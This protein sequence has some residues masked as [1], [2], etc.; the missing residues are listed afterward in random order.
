MSLKTPPRDLRPLAGIFL[1][2][3]QRTST[4]RSAWNVARRRGMADGGATADLRTATDLAAED[5]PSGTA[6]FG[7]PPVASVMR[8]LRDEE[9]ATPSSAEASASASPTPSPFLSEASASDAWLQ[10]REG[11]LSAMRADYEA[12]LAQAKFNPLAGAGWIA[13]TFS[14]NES[15][16]PTPNEPNAVFV[17]DPGADP[18]VIGYDD[19]GNPLF[20]AA[21]GRWLVF[22]VATFDAAYQAEAGEPL[23]ALAEVYDTDVPGVL[24]LPG[25]WQIA[26]SA[27]ALRAGP[28]L[29]GEAMGD[30][31][32]LG[33]LD[34]YMAD[35]QILALIDA[36]GG[37]PA[38][39][40][41]P[42]ALDQVRLYGEARYQQLSRLDNAMHEVRQHYVLA[43]RQA[44]LTGGTGWTERPRM[45]TTYD[46]SGNT[47]TGPMYLT[48]EFGIVRDAAGQPVVVTERF[49]DADAFTCWYQRQSGLANEA[50][51]N[52][53][54]ASHAHYGTDEVGNTYLVSVDF[55]N[56]RWTV[57]PLIGETGAMVPKVLVGIDPNDR[58]GLHDD[59]AIGFDL[60]AG[61]VTPATNVRD[62]P[63]WFERIFEVA[64]VVYVGWVFWPMAQA[65]GGAVG[66]AL[67]TV[68]GAAATGAVAGSISAATSGFIAGTPQFKDILRGA[69]SGALTGGLLQELG[70]TL[71]PA[72][73]PFVTIGLNTTVNGAM[74]AL[75]GGNFA[76]GAL[77]GFAASLA[78]TVRGSLEGEIDLAE[79]QGSMTP[80]QADAAKA[81]TKVLGSAIRAAGNPADPQSAFA[82]AFLSDLIE[83]TTV[84]P[85]TAFDDDG[86]LMPGAV[87]PNAPV[88]SQMA[89]LQARLIAQGLDPTRAASLAA[90]YFAD[91]GLLPPSAYSTAA[92]AARDAQRTI[93]SLAERYGGIDLVP[94]GELRPLVDA[95]QPSL[96]NLPM[97]L[98]PRQL[99]ALGGLAFA[100]DARRALPITV[101]V[102]AGLF[103]G[104]GDSA[105]G[106]GQLALTASKAQAY[107]VAGM[108]IGFGSAVPGGREAYESLKAIGEAVAEIVRSPG[109]YLGGA[110]YSA[111]AKVQDALDIAA[112]G[113]D[114][115][116]W[117][118]YGVEVG[119]VTFEVANLVLGAGG[120]A[121]GASSLGRGLTTW[122]KLVKDAKAVGSA[123]AFMPT[124][125]GRSGFMA[126]PEL[127]GVQPVAS[128]GVNATK[129]NTTG[130]GL[131]NYT[132]EE[133]ALIVRI[134]QG[135]DSVRGE[136]TEA[137][138]SSV[139]KREGLVEL[140]GG[141]YHGDSGKGFDHVFRNPDGTV[142]LLIES[143]Q[144]NSGAMRLNPNAAGNHMQMS[145]EWVRVVLGRLDKSSEAYA[146][147]NA[148]IEQGTLVKGLTG[149]DKT[150]GSLMIVRID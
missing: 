17:S 86:N 20:G 28:A 62:D 137:V 147:I 118:F 77:A 79:A 100:D 18:P 3:S 83:R 68:A 45:V 2:E 40:T 146:A 143:K 70:G 101:G 39:A 22:D 141:Q 99:A 5:E 126:L 60:E 11:A 13:A 110:A 125:S 59:T 106:L 78:A 7:A 80:E 108:D 43:L 130:Y 66:G 74:R 52:F 95:L 56:P 138:V 131:I 29:A 82:E 9:P 51:T 84:R 35:P 32:Q 26:T 73:N 127:Q 94:A 50:F 105:I 4:F 16:D 116:A 97:S 121:A 21:P 144:V 49:F 120:V 112:A 140:E 1:P 124:A 33:M 72:R 109:E 92:V 8:D 23:Q 41:A 142:T 139:A 114:A 14:I 65:A 15:S 46:E 63:G 69:F 119:K 25:L 34:L 107:V 64:A 48:D 98:D 129:F 54:G 38:A 96:D 122:V 12:A 145:D 53:Y 37:T 61:W 88:D 104:V 57:D 148:A 113:D 87:D 67:G 89:E 47:S 81:F 58:P 149:L 117:F 24:A 55:D 36:Y 30:P 76:D 132:A 111:G 136:L 123:E 128:G 115:N 134:Q 44:Q 10:W 75:L 135:E 93:A 31:A 6:L 91:A 42:I 133:R 103:Q 102:V 150:S 71:N 90:D 27:H 19:I 85:A